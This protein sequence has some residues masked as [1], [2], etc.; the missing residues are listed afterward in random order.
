[1]C[2]CVS[3][4]N[5][6]VPQTFTYIC[7]DIHQLPTR[8][9]STTGTSLERDELAGCMCMAL[10]IL[11]QRDEESSISLADPI[12]FDVFLRDLEYDRRANAVGELLWCYVVSPNPWLPLA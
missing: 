1:M 5:V 2:S 3:G 4:E 12:D 11:V 6:E 9:Q 7:S 10:P 8:G